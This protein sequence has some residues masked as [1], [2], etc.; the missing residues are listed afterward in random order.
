MIFRLTHHIYVYLNVIYN[1]Y[2]SSFLVY[3][4]NNSVRILSLLSISCFG[5]RI[6]MFNTV[7]FKN[8]SWYSTCNFYF[9]PSFLRISGFMSL[10]SINPCKTSVTTNISTRMLPILDWILMF[11]INISV[12]FVTIYTHRLLKLISERSEFIR[13][14]ERVRV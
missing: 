1:S 9:M 12:W 7:F 13:V 6:S 4:H 8:S 10:L 2:F 11:L 14:C 5:S 3:M